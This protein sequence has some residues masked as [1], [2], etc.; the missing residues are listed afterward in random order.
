MT[1]KGRARVASCRE[2]F[3]GREATSMKVPWATQRGPSPSTPSVNGPYDAATVAAVLSDARQRA[4]EQRMT[5]ELLLEEARVLEARVAEESEHARLAEQHAL[6]A[7]LTQAADE[8]R[9]QERHFVDRAE[10]A[11]AIIQELIAQ[12]HAAQ[13]HVDDSRAALALATGAFASAERRL[14][15]ARRAEDSARAGAEEIAQALERL[16]TL[17][18]T[19]EAELCSAQAQVGPDTGRPPSLS[20][21]DELSVLETR[22]G[23]GADAARRVSERRAADELR[24]RSI[25]S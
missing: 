13:Q 24:R 21:I 17:R 14:E 7:K 5:A 4:T 15:D 18:E 19:A 2:L 6:V 25:S 1:I 11:E 20:V 10:A 3:S 9:T 16:G 8:T 23:V 22:L 12:R